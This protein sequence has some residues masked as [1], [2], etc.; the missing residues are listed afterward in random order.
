MQTSL[1]P[2]CGY[3]GTSEEIVCP[4]GCREPEM[5]NPENQRSSPARLWLRVSG[6]IHTIVYPPNSFGPGSKRQA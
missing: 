1:C 4:R 2:G 6:D 5:S 3:Q